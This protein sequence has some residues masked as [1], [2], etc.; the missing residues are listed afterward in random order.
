MVFSL[1]FKNVLSESEVS[2]LKI[3]A[4][5]HKRSFTDGEKC[6]IV[7]FVLLNYQY[8]LGKVDIFR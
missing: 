8:Q 5:K 2:R 6:R 1:E 3:A 4:R 7:M